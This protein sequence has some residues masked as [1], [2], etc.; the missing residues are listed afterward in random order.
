[1]QPIEI[2]ESQLAHWH[3]LIVDAQG[4]ARC[5]L[6]E[7]LRFYLIMTLDAF[8]K[9]HKVISK[10]VAL[11]FLQAVELSPTESKKAMRRVGDRCLLIAG[12]FPEQAK[13]RNV[14]VTYYIGIGK[15]AYYNVANR[16]SFQRFDP[17]LFINLAQQ[18]VDLTKVLNA[19][20]VM[21]FQ[22]LLLQTE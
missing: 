22:R 7:N 5:S 6:D 4:I 10:V 8:T 20:R 9:E 17:E 2:A 14:S 1:M 3:E 16:E 21:P 12:L 11:D 13:R 15:Q 19:F 18:F